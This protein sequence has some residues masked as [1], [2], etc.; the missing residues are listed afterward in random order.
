MIKNIFYLF[1]SALDIQFQSTYVQLKDEI[2]SRIQT[3]RKAYPSIPD[4]DL[5]FDSLYDV[6]TF[7]IHLYTNQIVAQHLLPRKSIQLKD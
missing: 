2:K 3:S 1:Q 4:L 6:S 7:I 5:F